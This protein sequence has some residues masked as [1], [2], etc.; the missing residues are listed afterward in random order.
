MSLRMP[1][2]AFAPLAWGALAL[3]SALPLILWQ[4][5]SGA[6]APLWLLLAQAGALL[7]LLFAARRFPSLRQLEGFL[8]WLL[9][10]AV[11][12]HLIL[13]GVFAV[14]A[15]QEWQRGMPWVVRGAVVQVLV[16]VPTLLLVLFGV[17]RRGRRELRLA[18]GDGEASAFPDPYTL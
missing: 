12:W 6:P 9:A 13:G 18:W 2:P 16:F 15:W 7:A 8:L 3:G 11:G 5:L 14:P 4:E 1:S 17:G 10:L